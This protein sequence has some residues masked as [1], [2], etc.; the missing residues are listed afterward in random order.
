MLFDVDKYDNINT[1]F[2]MV[3]HY[4]YYRIWRMAVNC[5][6]IKNASSKIKYKERKNLCILN[7]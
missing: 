3:L 1:I 5:R 2:H 6:L 7:S 4:E